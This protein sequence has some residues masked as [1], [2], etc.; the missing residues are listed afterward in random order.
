MKHSNYV[1]NPWNIVSED[2]SGS[3]NSKKEKYDSRKTYFNYR[4][5]LFLVDT[6]DLTTL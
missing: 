5:F 3:I 4:I 2:T 1:D 6:F